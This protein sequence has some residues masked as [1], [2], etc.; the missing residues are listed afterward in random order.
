[1][2]NAFNWYLRCLSKPLPIGTYDYDF[3][4]HRQSAGVL[5]R[6]DMVSRLAEGAEKSWRWNDPE[7]TANVH[8]AVGASRILRSEHACGADEL[9]RKES[10][11]LSDEQRKLKGSFGMEN[12]FDYHR[13]RNERLLDLRIA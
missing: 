10:A 8:H 1:M 13:W 2:T 4:L 6:A 7:K 9:H 11:P 5:L 3:Y 12:E